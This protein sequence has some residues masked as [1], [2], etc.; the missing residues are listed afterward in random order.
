M[1]LVERKELSE[2]LTTRI[3]KASDN[4]VSLLQQLALGSWPDLASKLHSYT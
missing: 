4:M 2:T 1:T 3:K